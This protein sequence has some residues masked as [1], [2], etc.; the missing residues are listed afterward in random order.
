[1]IPV[2]ILF[3]IISCIFKLS[4]ELI[5]VEKCYVNSGLKSQNLKLVTLFDRCIK[6]HLKSEFLSVFRVAA[7][8]AHPKIPS[9]TLEIPIRWY[10]GR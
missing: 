4:N 6:C 3:L 1:M 2:P 10:F 8:I 9:Y 7:A 5:L